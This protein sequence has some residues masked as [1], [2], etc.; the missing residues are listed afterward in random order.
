M[1]DALYR[2]RFTGRLQMEKTVTKIAGWLHGASK[3]HDVLNT[4]KFFRNLHADLWMEIGG[5]VY[6]FSELFGYELRE[7][8]SH[9]ASFKR[10]LTEQAREQILAESGYT[11]ERD[12]VQTKLQD[13]RAQVVC[14]NAFS[15]VT[16]DQFAAFVKQSGYVTDAER[17]G[18]ETSRYYLVKNGLALVVGRGVLYV[19]FTN[20]PAF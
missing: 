16:V 20:S 9:N 3:L 12:R 7:A 13:P 6:S 10:S 2:H 5:G 15:R 19:F 1:I 17:E 14:A 18:G 4:V 11:A 8:K